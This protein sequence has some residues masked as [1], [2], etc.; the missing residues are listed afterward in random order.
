MCICS[1]L[2]GVEE[3]KR[4]FSYELDNAY[5]P[6]PFFSSAYLFR[7]PSVGSIFARNYLGQRPGNLGGLYHGQ[8]ST[9][10]PSELPRWHPFHSLALMLIHSVVSYSLQL[11]YINDYFSEPFVTPL[12]FPDSIHELSLHCI[13]IIMMAAFSCI[14]IITVVVIIVIL[15]IFTFFP[16]RLQDS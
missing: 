10:F 6:K 12:Y 9:E 5:L 13:D 4:L 11:T 7:L 14:M 1:L 2:S 3:C 8:H 15:L 16:N